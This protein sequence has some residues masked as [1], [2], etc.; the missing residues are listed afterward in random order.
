MSEWPEVEL[1]ELASFRNGLNYSAADRGCGLAV[2]GVS[3]FQGRSFVDFASL[4]QLGPSALGT[5]EA[6]IRRNDI[7]FVRSNGNRELIGR[8]LLVLSEPTI[9]T[10]HSGFTIRLRFEDDRADPRFFAY[11]L[12]SGVVRRV[13]ASQGGGTNINN[14]NQG[15]LSRLP[16]PLPPIETQ[17]RIAEIL[18]AYDDLIEVNRRRVAVLEDMARGLFEEWFVRLRFPGHESVPLHNI[19]DVP[20]PEGWRWGTAADVIAFDPRTKVTKDGTKPFISMGQ[21]DTVTSLIGEHEMREGNSGAKFQDGDTLFARIT[22][23]L[24]NGKTGLV[25]GLSELGGVGFGSTE[26]IVMRGDRV[27]PAFT[28]CLSRQPDFRLAAQQSMSGASGRQRAKT[29]S[30]ASF[31]LALPA[32][33]A[34]FAAFEKV[35]WPMLEMVGHIG[36][37][38]QRLAASRDLLLPRLMSGQLSMA[39]AQKELE[40]A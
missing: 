36:A 10:S 6:L 30:V 37:A 11:F 23:C 25:R 21:L 18:G 40:I 1:G 2:V 19:P 8:S 39:E 35:A 38:N 34:L 13:L 17:R 4:E 15:I 28:Y 5:P 12:R 16:V 7:L 29:D 3:D 24:E 14:L 27:G 26:F 32:N 9:P 33:D 22:P 20:L 31:Q